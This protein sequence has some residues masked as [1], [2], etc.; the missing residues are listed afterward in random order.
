LLAAAL[1]LQLAGQAPRPAKT[2]SEWGQSATQQQKV[3]GTVI[4]EL[5]LLQ[6]F[7]LFCRSINKKV[8]PV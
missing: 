2:N 8:G 7:V 4:N 6:A 1:P 3:E 5:S